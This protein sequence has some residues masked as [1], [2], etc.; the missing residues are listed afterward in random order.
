MMTGV[1]EGDAN[2][3]I[4]AECGTVKEL[5]AEALHAVGPR[6]D[7]PFATLDCGAIP[8]VA[9]DRELSGHVRAGVTLFLDGIGELTPHLQ[10]RLLHVIRTVKQFRVIAATT[11]E[12][13]QAMHVARFF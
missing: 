5:I 3:C 6:R 4:E 12:P 1:A 13:R 7:R 11:R 10:A 2:V 8:D 9:M